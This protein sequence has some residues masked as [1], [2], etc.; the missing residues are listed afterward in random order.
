MNFLIITQYYPPEMEGIPYEV[1]LG[2]ADR[3]HK[4]R[5]IT[6]FPNYPDGKIY[7]G[8]SQKWR[9]YERD[10]KI[11]ILRVPLYPDHSYNAV[12]RSANYLSFGLSSASAWKFA[13]GAD[14]IYV[15]ATQM[16]AT[17]GPWIWRQIGGAPYIAHVQ[18]L[19]PESIVGSSLVS[20]S[21][22]AQL[23]RKLISPWLS[24]TYRRAGGVVGIAPTMV[25]LLKE[26]GS[27]NSRT[28]LIYNWGADL[29]SDKTDRGSRQ[30][31]DE[32]LKLILAGNLGDMQGIETVLEAMSQVQDLDIR[33]TIAGSGVASDR[34]NV[35]ARELSLY[36]VNF[37]GRI[38]R[39]EMW[40]YY[41][42]ADFALVTLRDLEVFR[43]TI[44]SRFQAALA[45][46][47]PVITNVAGDLSDFV[48]D[49]EIGLVA[50]PEDS[51]SLA[52][53]MREA[54]TLRPADRE[55]YSKNAIET[56]QS[57]FSAKAGIDAI[58][59]LLTVAALESKQKK[60]R[61]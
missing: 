51:G 26:R 28:H 15:Y 44:P 59:Q 5:V 2:L 38:D 17:L 20:G 54:Y 39:S 21:A 61:N 36:N 56:Y 7:K 50:L 34:L 19:W 24:S 4:V 27:S 23:I 41:L 57:R 29:S 60:V 9:Q 3:G 49:N 1:A 47:V 46:G 58:E 35:Y 37:V 22:K 12:K 16:T 42:D 14:A 31:H 55:I 6:G 25:R 30:T 52:N 45:H 11:Q 43:A 18:D 10:G 53:V 32:A 40:K 13:R 48:R 33:L 8:Y